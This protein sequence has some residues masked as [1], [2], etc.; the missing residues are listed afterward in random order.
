MLNPIIYSLRNKDVRAA[1]RNLVGQKHLTEWLSQCRT[2]NLFIVFVREEWCNEE[3]PLP[4]G[5]SNELRT[6]TINKL[7]TFL[8]HQ[9]F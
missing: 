1:V 8:K 9:C 2:S 5:P 6:K 7:S 4:Q 3:E